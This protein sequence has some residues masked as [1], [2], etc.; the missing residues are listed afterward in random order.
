MYTLLHLINELI[1]KASLDNEI[2]LDN[3]DRLVNKV[4]RLWLN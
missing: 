1:N 4:K 3:K 2:R